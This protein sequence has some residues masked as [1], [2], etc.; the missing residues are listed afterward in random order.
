[1][2]DPGEQHPQNDLNQQSGSSRSGK[3][4]V[5]AAEIRRLLG[6]KKVHVRMMPSG[7]KFTFGLER[8]TVLKC[9]TTNEPRRV[10]EEITELR[11]RVK[12]ERDAG[13]VAGRLAYLL[14]KGDTSHLAF[15]WA[16]VHEYLRFLELKLEAEDID[17]TRLSPSPLIDEV[18][19][20]HILDTEH[21]AADCNRI[22]LLHFPNNACKIVHHSPLRTFD[23][24]EAID[25]RRE[26]TKKAYVLRF[27]T[28]PDEAYW[29]A[30]AQ[31]AFTHQECNCLACQVARRTGCE[32]SAL[33]MMV[34]GQ[35][36]DPGT[37]AMDFGLSDGAMLDAVEWKRKS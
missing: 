22:A 6:P 3:E 5:A 11:G 26:N 29:G 30:N 1:M 12:K 18:W 32:S 19:H 17:G 33:R 37:N 23:A 24:D 20:Q 27:G 25:R 36:V 9:S 28:V 15:V 31:H 14:T 13:N 8:S 2:T 10:P 35:P 34:Y 21:Y 4:P 16:I 7:E